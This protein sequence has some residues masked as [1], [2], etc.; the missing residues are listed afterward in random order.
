MDRHAKILVA[1]DATLIGSAIL[2]HLQNSGCAHVMG[3]PHALDLTC[4]RSVESY[5]AEMQPD[6]VF[7]AA[8]RSG[9]IAA[10]QSFP[11]DLMR[12]NLLVESH[13][14]HNA[15]QS[16]VRKLVYL[17]SSCC[18]PRLAAQPMRE[19][20]L[21]TGPLEPTNEAYALAK[22][23]GIKLCQAYNR[24]HGT[25][26]VSV[27]PANA[28]GPGDD[29]SPEE[30]HVIAALIRKV[31]AAKAQGQDEVEV[32]GSGAP[33]REFIY[34]PDL[35]D[36]CTMVIDRYDGTEPINIGAGTDLSIREL[37]EAV[38]ETVGY[39][40]RLRFDAS[41]PDGMPRKILDSGKLHRLGWR[42][43]TLFMDALAETYAW[44]LHH[45]AERMPTH[46]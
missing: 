25:R 34:A 18:Y 2:R 39:S 22:I 5:F 20:A 4:A 36:A 31:H 24:Q 38:C 7:L 21:L 35:A 44:F 12:D 30:S 10:N 37:A 43:R 17:A 27:I 19:E 28:F 41:K 8:G 26:F 32:W 15:Y 42:P 14:I 3:T 23:A 9:G 1:G 13:I 33:R 40:G 46:A 29:F 6:Y 11:A 45:E 16:R